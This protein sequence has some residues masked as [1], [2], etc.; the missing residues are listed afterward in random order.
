LE[1]QSG[2][3]N[4]RWKFAKNLSILIAVSFATWL[5]CDHFKV[6]LT[7]SLNKRVFWSVMDSSK[8]KPIKSGWYIIFDQYVPKPTDRLLTFIKRAGCVAGDTLTVQNDNYNCNGKFI[9]KAKRMSL[10]GDPLVPFVF[11]GKVPEGM[12]FAIG[13]HPDSFD[14]RYF[15]F[16]LRSR[17]KEVAWSLL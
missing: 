13:D 12:V 15:G 5:F 7:N 1:T 4:S 6:T 16:I 8:E 14:S 17:V 3:K 9:G 10:V 2:L 11:N